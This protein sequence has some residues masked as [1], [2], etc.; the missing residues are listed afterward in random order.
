MG[1]N[2]W[3]MGIILATPHAD[4]KERQ[5]IATDIGKNTSGI[6]RKHL[7]VKLKLAEEVYGICQKDIFHLCTHIVYWSKFLSK[8]CFTFGFRS[9]YFKEKLWKKE[10]GNSSCFHSLHSPSG[11]PEFRWALVAQSLNCCIN[12]IIPRKMARFRKKTSMFCFDFIFQW[13]N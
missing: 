13:G 1:E 11:L 6:I 2:R 7:L 9:V 5:K 10:I 8:S 4:W 12:Q 3:G